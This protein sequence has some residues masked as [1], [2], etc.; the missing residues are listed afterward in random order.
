M[1]PNSHSWWNRIGGSILGIKASSVSGVSPHEDVATTR[2]TSL[3]SSSASTSGA[4]VLP[5]GKVLY[6]PADDVSSAEAGDL[7]SDE[8]QPRTASVSGYADSNVIYDDAMF[9][10]ELGAPPLS[11]CASALQPTHN[12]VAPPTIAAAAGAH[13]DAPVSPDGGMTRAPPVP[14][15]GV[16]FT[17]GP[18]VDGFGG[19][20]PVVRDMAEESFLFAQ[21][22]SPQ[23]PPI[24]CSEFLQ[25]V[26]EKQHEV[27]RYLHAPTQDIHP[28]TLM[29]MAMMK[30][31]LDLLSSCI[32]GVLGKGQLQMVQVGSVATGKAQAL[33]QDP[34][35]L[36]SGASGQVGQQIWPIEP[37]VEAA[38]LRI[39]PEAAPYV[40]G[41]LI[42]N[43][44]P[45]TL[46]LAED[47]QGPAIFQGF[48]PPPSYAWGRGEVQEPESPEIAN[49]QQ[50]AADAL[51]QS[52][53]AAPPMPRP[54]TVETSSPLRPPPDAPMKL[55][56]VAAMDKLQEARSACAR[57][58][59]E[60]RGVPT[61]EVELWC[62]TIAERL[63]AASATLETKLEAYKK[64]SKLKDDTIKKLHARL[65]AAERQLTAANS[66]RGDPE[67]EENAATYG[68]ATDWPGDGLAYRGLSNDGHNRSEGSL[69]LD[70]SGY[71]A[72]P[73]MGTVTA[74]PPWTPGDTLITSLSDGDSILGEA[75]ASTPAALFPEVG[76]CLSGGASSSSQAGGGQEDK[77]TA[78]S[79]RVLAEKPQQHAAISRREAA[80]LRRRDAELA[81]QL[82]AR[83]QQVE[84]LSTTLRE[85]HIVTQR[86]IGLYKRQLHLKD[87]ML[88][89]DRSNGQA[90][91]DGGLRR[92]R[93]QVPS[94]TA[95]TSTLL[96][97]SAHYG[98]GSLSGAQTPSMGPPSQGGVE[99]RGA[100]AGTTPRRADTDR[101]RG[102]PALAAYSG[103]KK[104]GNGSA[105][106]V[107]APQRRRISPTTPTTTPPLGRPGS[108]ETQRQLR[109][110]GSQA[111]PLRNDSDPVAAAA[112]TK[113]IRYRDGAP[114]QRIVRR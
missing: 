2:G 93:R 8:M 62:N 76:P 56:L 6:M 23:L 82:R 18:G 39:P 113:V 81:G 72:P 15:P 10:Q 84:Q 104:D 27:E 40:N 30:N 94:S 24:H 35:F 50:L 17:V 65:Q 19:D 28:P 11:E 101:S 25:G 48:Q 92:D 108:A 41:Q 1:D 100:R 42:D 106:Q 102:G 22:A 38:E 79:P 53:S 95:S 110:N 58:R 4:G 112:P 109:R 14:A 80:L 99:R 61:E 77:L 69:L 83:D 86:Q 63:Q 68:R 114:A 44:A 97:A 67:G 89:K 46:Q 3:T 21:V 85:L 57:L 73:F 12:F 51:L 52:S 32:A 78:A 5:Q 43:H 16:T 34:R 33:V 71:V 70:S 91:A 47:H 87:C 59:Q 74:P 55:A 75:G 107:A 49:E 105:P 9:A 36:A 90:L 111:P 103:P 45:A 26:I 31:E 7:R 13:S 54:R 98:S 29:K 20:L 96:A 64:K 66:A 88:D 60:R 37:P